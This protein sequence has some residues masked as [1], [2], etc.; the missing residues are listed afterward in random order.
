MIIQSIAASNLF[1]IKEIN[2]TEL[3]EK[4]LITI[5]G[6]NRLAKE[7]VVEAI[8]FA[9]FGRAV[10]QNVLY[11][12]ASEAQVT[13]QFSLEDGQHY[14]LVRTI[15]Y[16][17]EQRITLQ[18]MGGECTQ[19]P[20]DQSTINELIGFSYEFFIENL[21]LAESDGKTDKELKKSRDKI[22][23]ELKEK[24]AQ[25]LSLD[26]YVSLFQSYQRSIRKSKRGLKQ[27]NFFQTA[28]FLYTLYLLIAALSVIFMPESSLSKLLVESLIAQYPS[29]DSTDVSPLFYSIVGLSIL[30]ASTWGL[31]FVLKTRINGLVGV[32]KKMAEVL[33]GLDKLA[34]GAP[35]EQ[36]EVRQR[37]YRKLLDDIAQPEEVQ[38]HVDEVRPWVEH[39]LDQNRTKLCM[40]EYLITEANAGVGT[41]KD[42]I[43]KAEKQLSMESIAGQFIFVDGYNQDSQLTNLLSNNRLLHQVWLL[44][45]RQPEACEIAMKIQCKNSCGKLMVSGSR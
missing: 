2:L 20:I 39:S 22:A 21:L 24:Q 40:A 30:M 18:D 31:S 38:N 25:L 35:V 14:E 7:S 11:P 10:S 13:L 42:R 12:G 37:L 36:V 34:S 4:G 5:S 29:W 43:A 16:H 26:H 8:C 17:A 23:H 32:P 1:N 45:D 27:S 28:M 6:E 3:P 33:S 15:N 44:G 41:L 9:L 19:N